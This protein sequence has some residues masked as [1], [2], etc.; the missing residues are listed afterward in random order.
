MASANT[1]A[2]TQDEL[3]RI[4]VRLTHTPEEVLE[5][6]RLR[7][8]VFYEEYG[9][10]ASE[11]MKR[12]KRDFDDFDEIADHLIVLQRDDNGIE[13]IVGTYRLLRQSIAENF[14]RFYSADEYKLDALIKS[15]M[16]LLELGRSC[17]LA[18]YRT[19]P[20]LN[21][22]WHGIANYITE[23]NIDILFG[24][25]SFQGTDIET[26]KDQLSYLHHFHS[27]PKD[28]SPIAINE[29][30]VDMN[31]T[32][33]EELNEKHVFASLPP[34]IKGYLRLGATI[35]NGAVIDTQ[36]NTTDVCI[37]VQT[38]T[39]TQRYRKY[40]ER[41]IRKSMPGQKAVQEA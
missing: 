17:V 21:M 4:S 22:L 39:M 13:K 27:T 2:I 9:A 3:D 25:A 40:Y 16:S 29:R 38:S 24:C 41:R 36:F 31:I 14:G 34:L 32:P 11:T 33:K 10:Q 7:Y 12:E 5:A 8:A 35:G 30:Y 1:N 28:I 15:D 20:V 18:E 37:V 23:H 19:Q 26:I 6:Q